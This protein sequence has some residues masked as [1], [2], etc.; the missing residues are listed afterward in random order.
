VIYSSYEYRLGLPPIIVGALSNLYLDKYAPLAGYCSHLADL[1]AKPEVSAFS[2]T[3]D[4]SRDGPSTA[5]SKRSNGSTPAS[6]NSRSAVKLEVDYNKKSSVKMSTQKAPVSVLQRLMDE[7][8]ILILKGKVG[9]DG[10]MNEDGERHGKGIYTYPNGEKYIGKGQL[11]TLLVGTSC[12][13][14]VTHLRISVC[15]ILLKGDWEHGRRHGCGYFQHSNGDVYSGEFHQDKERGLCTLRY[16]NGDSFFGELHHGK[17][18]GHG[19]VQYRNGDLYEGEF[20]R[21]MRHG[22]GVFKFIDGSVYAG[23]FKDDQRHGFGVLTGVTGKVEYHGMWKNNKP[24]PDFKPE[25]EEA[26]T[27]TTDG[28]GHHHKHHHHHHHK[29]HHH[30]HHHHDGSD[31]E[32]EEGEEEKSHRKHHHKHSAEEETSSVSPSPSLP[33]LAAKGDAADPT[34]KEK[35]AEIKKLFASQSGAQ[36]LT[37]AQIEAAHREEQRKE[38]HPA[39]GGKKKKSQSP[40]E[41]VND[42]AALPTKAAE[43]AHALKTASTDAVETA[44]AHKKGAKDGAHAG[45]A[46][47]AHPAPHKKH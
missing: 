36:V 21:D 45:G 20:S 28:D 31:G 7:L 34:A 22:E 19:L 17:K 12:G 1:T 4:A 23:K 9:Y 26:D 37:I 10:E 5:A 44:P 18:I 40:R 8:K 38:V 27:E 39:K 42:F 46:K 2:P 6:T 13:N 3:A 29:H 47:H 11:V 43:A 41:E 32:A 33:N 16:A 15:K 35:M 14:V 24:A 25:E 30:H